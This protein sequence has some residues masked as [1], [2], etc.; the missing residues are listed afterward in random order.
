MRNSPAFDYDQP[1]R[2]ALAGIYVEVCDPIAGDV[3]DKDTA[4]QVPCD[5]QAPPQPEE[6]FGLTLTVDDGMPA[7]QT[8]RSYS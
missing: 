8:N 4:M 7:E 1:S 6:L 5:T 2:D 3:A